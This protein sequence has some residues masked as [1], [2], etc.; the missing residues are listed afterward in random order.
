MVAYLLPI[1]GALLDLPVLK[2][3]QR[4]FEDGWKRLDGQE[5]QTKVAI[6]FCLNRKADSRQL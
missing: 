5:E 6:G 4:E 2:R 3:Y 1:N